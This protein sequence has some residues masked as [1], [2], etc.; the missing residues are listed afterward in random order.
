MDG[1]AIQ[2]MMAELAPVIRDY[3]DEK[4][5]PVVRRLEA[6]EVGKANVVTLDEVKALS[7]SQARETGEQAARA[8][9][10][11]VSK[12]VRADEVRS[13]VAE[14]LAS[15]TEPVLEGVAR[16]IEALESKPPPEI[17]TVV[18]LRLVQDEV[19]KLPVP[20]DGKDADPEAIAI[21]VQETLHETF[22]ETA[23]QI[24][25]ESIADG[26]ASLS[27]PEKGEPGDK[28]EPGQDGCGIKDLMQDHD[29]NLVA[30]FDDGRMKNV[31]PVRGK[32]GEKGLDGRDGRDGTDGKDGRD[33][34]NLED[35][36]CQP[37]D[38]RTIKLMFTR[39]DI[40]H[41]FELEFPVIIDRGVFR[42]G[43]EYKRGDAVTWGGSLWIAQQETTAKPDSPESGWRLAVKKGRDGK[44]SK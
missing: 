4:F 37:I 27:P 35:F 15:A 21:Q 38:E 31:G 12:L 33:G 1:T 28:G 22:R 2:A 29:G 42:A 23:Q 20:Q 6:V 14:E 30:T 25:A 24:V 9:Q 26:L 16:R 43:E 34:F 7:V 36:D 5:A 10:D 19:A 3:I 8:I 39:G 41:S 18:V 11:S 17:D 44:D 13:I 40:M 32:D